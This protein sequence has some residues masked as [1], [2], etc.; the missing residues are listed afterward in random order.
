MTKSTLA[1]PASDAIVLRFRCGFAVLR[2]VFL[3]GRGHASNAKIALL[4]LINLL[5]REP[6]VTKSTLAV[7]SQNTVNTSVFEKVVQKHC[8]IQHFG[9]IVLRKCRK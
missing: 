7:F 8:K 4:S 2:R 6:S 5:S 3:L 1:V 9:H